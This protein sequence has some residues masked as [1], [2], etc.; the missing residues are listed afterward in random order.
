MKFGKFFLLLAAGLLLAGC[1]SV[2]LASGMYETTL[3]GRR[4]SAAVYGDMIILRLRNPE[5][6]SGTE[7]GYWDWGGKYEIRDGSQIF[8]K[9]D[10]ETARVWGFYYELTMQKDGIKV[11]DHRAENSYRLEYV[12]AVPNQNRGRRPAPSAYPAY[13]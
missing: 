4:D 10:R 8:L 13:K 12:P 6:E 1:E 9:M 2:Q 7:E 11:T 3:P 5:N